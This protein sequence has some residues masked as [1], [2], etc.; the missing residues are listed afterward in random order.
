M[1][2]VRQQ[3]FSSVVPFHLRED[4]P[5]LYTL[6]AAPVS[7]VYSEAARI[8]NACPSFTVTQALSGQGFCTL[9]LSLMSSSL[10]VQVEKVAHYVLA[11]MYSYRYVIAVHEVSDSS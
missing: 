11:T 9:V 10:L 3:V 7:S 4:S 1:L 8:L 5:S 2:P 6:P